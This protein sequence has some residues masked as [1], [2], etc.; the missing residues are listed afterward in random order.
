M[1]AEHGTVLKHNGSAKG[2]WVRVE[3][4]RTATRISVLHRS[5]KHVFWT[6]FRIEDGGQIKGANEKP[7]HKIKPESFKPTPI[8]KAPLPTQSFAEAGKA[9]K[10]MKK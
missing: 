9:K 1:E 3:A 8:K 7:G 6:D 5:K 10:V 2:K 4:K